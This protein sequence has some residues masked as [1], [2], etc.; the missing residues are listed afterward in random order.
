MTDLKTYPALVRRAEML[1][2]KAKIAIEDANK[3]RGAIKGHGRRRFVAA[4]VKRGI[5]EKETL[6]CIKGEKATWTQAAI[7]D[8]PGRIEFIGYDVSPPS[9]SPHSSQ[10]WLFQVSYSRQKKRGGFRDEYLRLFVYG[11]TPEEAAK[12]IE[13]WGA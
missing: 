6:I 2:R 10:S 8:V 7:P 5:I 3:A 13:K 11:K 12:K 1:E 4:L 9:A